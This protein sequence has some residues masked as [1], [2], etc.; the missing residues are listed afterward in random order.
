MRE[1]APIRIGCSTVVHLGRVEKEADSGRTWAATLCGAGG[2]W[3]GPAHET[4][5]EPTCPDCIRI[6]A[7]KPKKGRAA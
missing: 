2:R 6:E 4:Q 1:N 3:G 7:S 5:H